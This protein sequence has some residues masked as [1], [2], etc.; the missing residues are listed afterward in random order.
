MDHLMDPMDYKFVFVGY[1]DYEIDRLIFIHDRVLWG[2][3]IPK[4][5]AF[6]RQTLKDVSNKYESV[7]FIP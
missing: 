5:P 1:F 7:F 3:E 2:R 6:T 4:Q